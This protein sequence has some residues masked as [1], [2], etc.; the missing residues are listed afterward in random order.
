MVAGSTVRLLQKICSID[1]SLYGK[2]T[3]EYVF[4][5]WQVLW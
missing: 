5:L 4:L 1:G 3:L 2:V